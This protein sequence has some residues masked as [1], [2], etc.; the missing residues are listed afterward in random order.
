[1][2]GSTEYYCSMYLLSRE[3]VV[4]GDIISQFPLMPIQLVTGPEYPDER[5]LGIKY[6]QDHRRQSE[7]C[8][9][10]LSQ[11]TCTVDFQQKL[12]ALLGA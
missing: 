6:S 2:L 11:K 4:A 5:L 3:K 10:Q 1:M 12:L 8:I 7:T 9:S